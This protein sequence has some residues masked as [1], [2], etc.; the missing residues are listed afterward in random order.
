MIPD[1]V[2]FLPT[3][4]TLMS[5]FDPVAV[6]LLNQVIEK[7]GCKIVIS[8]TWG[9]KGLKVCSDLLRDNGIDPKHLHSDWI[10]PRKMSSDRT[11]EISWWLKKHPETIHWAALDDAPLDF[12]REER[13]AH[14]VRVTAEDGL[15]WRHYRR[16]IE[17]LSNSKVKEGFNG[18]S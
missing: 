1:R 8:S 18:L 4:T 13:R 9:H 14:Y 15:L 12:S 6:S 2:C 5:V 16:L 10:T 7:T 3:Q 17:L 11:T